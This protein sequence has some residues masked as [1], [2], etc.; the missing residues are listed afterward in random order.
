VVDTVTP[1]LDLAAPD[2]VPSSLRRSGL[3]VRATCSEACTVVARLSV[4]AGTASRLHL[5]HGRA[6]LGSAE[7][8]IGGAGTRAL[9]IRL[10]DRVRKRLKQ[11]HVTEATLNVVAT[12]RAGNARGERRELTGG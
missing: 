4:A 8:K 1:T 6:M 12:D 9:R 2:K 3:L 5:G 10:T 11:R 7:V